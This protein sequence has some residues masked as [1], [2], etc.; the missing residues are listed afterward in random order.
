MTRQINERCEA[1][2]EGGLG[3][4]TLCNKRMVA[5]ATTTKRMLTGLDGTKYRPKARASINFVT[6]RGTLLSL[7]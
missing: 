7:R 1:E 2:M 3:L 4:L 5:F 6:T